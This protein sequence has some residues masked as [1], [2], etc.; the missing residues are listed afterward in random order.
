M[1]PWRARPVPFCF[2]GLAPPPATSA[3]VRVLWVPA[4]RAASWAVTTWCITATLGS[5]PKRAS[6]R[7]TE[8]LSAP[9][10]VFMVMVGIAASL[11][12][13]GRRRAL[14]RVAD[15]DDAALGAGHGALDEQ[16]ALLDVGLDHPQVQ[17]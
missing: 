4:R 7:S 11:P 5:M 2:H 8:P 3:R 6:S 10:A 12:R 13:R 9:A 16:R 1:E 15:D 17:R 14:D